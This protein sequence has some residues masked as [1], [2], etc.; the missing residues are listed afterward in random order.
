MAANFENLEA[1]YET[2]IYEDGISNRQ[3]RAIR[4]KSTRER[5]TEARD[6]QAQSGIR[7]RIARPVKNETDFM[8]ELKVWIPSVQAGV[9]RRKSLGNLAMT[10][11]DTAQQPIRACAG[12]TKEEIERR[13]AS[14]YRPIFEQSPPIEVTGTALFG[15]L[16]RPFIGLTLAPGFAF[17]ERG[18]VRPIV[19][20]ELGLDDRHQP[21]HRL[22]VSL[23]QALSHERA[24]EIQAAL[25][26]VLPNYVQFRPATVSVELDADN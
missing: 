4:G 25:A 15:N 5:L 21:D 1:A 22:H 2:R 6:A 10:V 26:T 8:G 20:P 23:G 11:F 17:K 24:I 18:I 7:V 9:A 16:S 19:A 3:R 13:L 12:L 14:Q